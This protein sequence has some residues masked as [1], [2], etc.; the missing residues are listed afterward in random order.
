MHSS[1]QHAADY[2]DPECVN[3]QCIGPLR[4]LCENGWNGTDCSE[5]ESPEMLH[6]IYVIM[7]NMLVAHY[8]IRN[9]I[10]IQM[11]IAFL[12]HI[13]TGNWYMLY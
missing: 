2:C 1:Q 12:R 8:S 6:S 4:C 9:I 11:Y 5:C 7:Y 13:Y 10:S 3:G